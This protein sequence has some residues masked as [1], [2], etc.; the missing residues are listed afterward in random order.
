[1]PS[2]NAPGVY[3]QEVNDGPRPI[4]SVSTSVAALIGV[5]AAAEER[6]LEVTPIIDLTQYERAFVTPAR[7]S[8]GSGPVPE[9]TDLG[10]AVEGFFAN[11]GGLCL[12]VNLGPSPT[13]A[14]LRQALA[15]L[16]ARD[17]VS[18]LAAPGLNDAAFHTEL[19][20]HCELMEDRFAILDVP[21]VAEDMAQLT[22]VA[23]PGPAAEAPA[24]AEG[25]GGTAETAEGDDAGESTTRR[26]P[27]RAERVNM[28]PR[29]TEYAALYY[30]RVV[31]TD[32]VTG[33]P[34]AAPASGHIAGVYA[35]VDRLRG[36]HKAPANE[37]IRGVIDLEDRVDRHVQG[38]LN[39]AGVNVIRSFATRGIR[40]WGARTL[41]TGS[42]YTY[43]NV[44]RFV[45]MIKE[46]IEIGTQW[47]V[48][49]PNGYDLWSI[50]T[51]D[52]TAY[53][54][55]VWRDGALLGA[56]PAEAFFVKCDRE[57]N[58]DEEIDAGY[59]TAL[60]GIAPVKPAEF[61]IIKIS[62]NMSSG[63]TTE[64]V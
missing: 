13:A 19:I 31:V 58:P 10:I 2:V 61:V 49:E 56:T 3:V 6:V 40:I 60:I 33:R 38:Q 5:A 59:L 26:R 28:R 64:G 41:A 55:R 47:V 35:R 43:V 9:P 32:P 63:S 57:T 21:G 29:D 1:M 44:R 20:D 53:L 16:R 54:T 39:Q 37:P 50:L 42:E 14:T 4:Q 36:V 17:E 18:V 52:L 46:S 45:N 15:L 22:T 25:A 48:F 7:G 11:G 30:P 27:A 34:R 51:R 23:T 8:D 62:Q 24:D 12:V